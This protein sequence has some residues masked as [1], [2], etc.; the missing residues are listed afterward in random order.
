MW[1]NAIWMWIF[2]KKN[3]QLNAPIYRQRKQLFI[4][5]VGLSTWKNVETTTWRNQEE[6]SI[7]YLLPAQQHKKHILKVEHSPR[8]L[9]F[10][11]SVNNERRKLKATMKM[12]T[13]SLTHDECLPSLNFKRQS[14][15]F[16]LLSH[17]YFPH[18]KINSYIRKKIPS[19]L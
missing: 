16:F 5:V 4:H 17:H 11:Q 6:T 12:S 9:L 13:R 1:G 14:N 2:W 10:C 7:Y 8:I 3:A 18:K 19:F 15:L